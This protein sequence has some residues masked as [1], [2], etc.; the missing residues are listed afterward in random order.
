M[1]RATRAASRRDSDLT[2]TADAGTVRRM[3]SIMVVAT[4]ASVV[5]AEPS[6][7]SSFG[8]WFDFGYYASPALLEERMTDTR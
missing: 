1:P 3:E 8:Y 5:S 7:L 4:F 2:S 6:G